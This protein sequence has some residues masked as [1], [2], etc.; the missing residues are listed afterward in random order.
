MVETWAYL[1]EMRGGRAGGGEGLDRPPDKK[2][3][4]FKK[5]NQKVEQNPENQPAE[6]L[7]NQGQQPEENKD[8]VPEVAQGEVPE[9]GNHEGKYIIWV[10]L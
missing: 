9:T 3:G 7:Q 10:E 2:L 5:K 4:A 8:I 6:N 1:A